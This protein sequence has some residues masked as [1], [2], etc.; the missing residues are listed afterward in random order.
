MNIK[1]NSIT[2]K[3]IF[4]KIYQKWEEMLHNFKRFNRDKKII[5]KIR[6]VY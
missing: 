2:C 1:K 4:D 6:K 5:K 3:S